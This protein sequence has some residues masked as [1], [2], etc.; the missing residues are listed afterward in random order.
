MIRQLIKACRP[1]QWYKNL[2]IFL[3]IFFAQSLFVNHDFL[4]IVVGLISLCFVSSANYIFNDIIDIKKDK[5]HPEKRLRPIASGK[6][7]IWQA[8]VLAIILLILSFGI[9]FYLAAFFFYSVL[10]LFLLTLVYS[11]W[12]KN[13]PFA[14]ILVI[15]VNFVVRAASGVFI[16]HIHASRWL[17]LCTFFLALFLAVGK[18]ESELRFLGKK[19]FESRKVLKYYTLELTNALVIIATSAL[20]LSYS[21]YAFL[22]EQY[23]LIYTL[24]FALY[25]IIRF[26]SFIYSGSVIARRAELIVT[27]KRLLLGIVLWLFVTFLILYY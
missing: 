18:R 2:V 16:L 15:S 9:A 24:P 6:V 10:F 13:E 8:I 1:Q 22:N 17:I 27:D 3:P 7:K 19:A 20:I 14:D 25:V 21:L 23:N 4:W 11:L 12:L 26:L 5:I